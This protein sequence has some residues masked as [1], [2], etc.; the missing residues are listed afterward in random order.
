MSVMTLVGALTLL[1]CVGVA[2]RI[3]PA[4]SSAGLA[5]PG[6][7]TP[8]TTQAAVPSGMPTLPQATV[9]LTMPTQTGTIWNVPAGDAAT[10]QSDINGANCGDTIVLVAGSTYTGNFTIPNKVCSGWILI[11]SSALSSLPASNHRV[12]PSDAPNMAKIS[13]PNT[14]PAI[15]FLARSHNWRLIGLEITTSHVGTNDMVYNLVLSD[16][17]LSTFTATLPSYVIFDRDYIVGLPNTNVTRGIDM[18]FVSAGI[19]DSYCDEIHNNGFDSQCFYAGNGPGPFLIQNNFIQAAGENIMFGGNDPSIAN[20]IPSDIT[21]VGNIFQKNLAWRGEAA[22]YNWVVKNLFE[23]KNGQRILIDGN[24]FQYAWAA[25]QNEAIIIRSVSNGSAL[26]SVCQDFTITHNL[27]QHQ[28]MGL[29]IAGSDTN[30]PPAQPTARILVQNNVISDSNSATWGGPGWLFHLAPG[31]GLH[32]V[33]IDH[34]TGFDSNT[35]MWLSAGVSPYPL[36]ISNLQITNNIWDYGSYGIAGDGTAGNP[37]TTLGTYVTNLTLN[38]VVYP[39]TTQNNNPSGSLWAGSLF[40]VG[41]TSY[42]G[43]DPNLSGNFQLTSG[44]AYHN[45]GTDGKDIGVWD[46]ATFNTETTNAL[47]GIHP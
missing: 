41:F 15:E 36:T 39:T 17:N 44:S 5:T 3:S 27:I 4:T 9:D 25:G 29:V 33:I 8:I 46:W 45:A 7:A 20:L 12:G 37:N 28:P 26:W 16:G 35:A 11:E 42:S 32:D 18:D 23:C 40:G 14:S 34:N 31:E 2:T 6:L 47:N 10:F 19:V 38:E 21:I 43:T 22:P 13:T 24:V 1:G 30:F